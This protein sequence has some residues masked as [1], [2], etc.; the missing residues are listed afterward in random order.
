MEIGIDIVYIPE[1]MKRMEKD[2]VLK[3]VFTF[4]ELRENT[5]IESLAAIFAA[6]EAFFKALGKKEDWHSVWVEKE[7]SGKPTL[8]TT[9]L[10][11]STEVKISL[12]HEKDY[13]IAMVLI[14]P[15]QGDE[16]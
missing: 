13:A 5:R 10:P 11:K 8:H 12:S 7:T 3:K 16:T 15:K 2:G 14:N 9:L 6:K 1:F 4:Y